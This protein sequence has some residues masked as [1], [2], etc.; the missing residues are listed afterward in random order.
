MENIKNNSLQ[1]RLVV[2]NKM[3]DLLRQ[4]LNHRF[5]DAGL[6]CKEGSKSDKMFGIDYENEKYKFQAKIRHHSKGIDFIY[7]SDQIFPIFEAGSVVGYNFYPGR[8]AKGISDY[9]ICKPAVED[10]IY[11]VKTAYVKKIVNEFRNQW[12]MPFKKVTAKNGVECEI[13]DFSKEIVDKYWNESNNNWRKSSKMYSN[14]FVESWFGLDKNYN[15]DN[16][17]KIIFYINPE[18]IKAKTILIRPTEKFDS[19]RSWLENEGESFNDY[20]N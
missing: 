11:V 7:E 4:Y 12:A 14:D 6:N 20:L 19:P 3:A 18:K 15:Y 9:Y 13:I 17:G 2:G 5:K 16:F 1:D 8:D 10:K